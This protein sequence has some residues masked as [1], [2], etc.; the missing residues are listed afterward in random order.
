[1]YFLYTE[2]FHT[3]SPLLLVLVISTCVN[4][5]PTT[6]SSLGSINSSTTSI[7]GQNTTE[8]PVTKG[9]TKIFIISE[10]LHIPYI[11]CCCIAVVLGF[12][13]VFFGKYTFNCLL[14]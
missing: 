7:D 12:F 8:Q 1:M 10:P 14:F 11:V 9:C 2:M 6:S 4:S 3:K 5:M 13:L